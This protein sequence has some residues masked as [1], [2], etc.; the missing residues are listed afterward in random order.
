MRVYEA[1]ETSERLISE[2]RQCQIEFAG[3]VICL[4]KVRPADAALNADYRRELSELSIGL[5]GNGLDDM[6]EDADREMLWKI[7]AK[8][9]ISEWEWVDP[10]DKKDPKLKFSEKN[11]VALFRRVPKFFQ[12]IQRVALQW[13]NFRVEHEEAAAGN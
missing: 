7:Y 10:A 6:D 11:A 1:F 2:G 5:K 3:K 8:T 4:V 13:S 12:G 9:V